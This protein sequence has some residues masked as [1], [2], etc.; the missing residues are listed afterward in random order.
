MVNTSTVITGLS[1][2]FLHT[3]NSL[4]KIQLMVVY[5]YNTLQSL[6]SPLSVYTQLITHTH[7]KYT[8][9]VIQQSDIFEHLVLTQFISLDINI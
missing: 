4:C 7:A 6:T 3:F 8:I 2:L 9:I 1:L 5:K